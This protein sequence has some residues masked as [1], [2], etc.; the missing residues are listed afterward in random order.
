MTILN[1][2]S[3]KTAQNMQLDAGILV[4]NLVVGEE[5]NADN[6]LGATSGGA[7]FSATPTFRNLFADI[8]GVR[9]EI[10]EGVVID[11]WEVKLTATIKE[12]T[13]ENI[14]LA[15]GAVKHNVSATLSKYEVLEPQLKVDKAMFQNIS[16]VGNLNGSDE[17]VVIELLNVLNANGL[18]FTATDKGSGSVALELKAHVTLDN[19]N[20]VPFKVY[21]PKQA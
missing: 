10:A 18:S 15:L 11:S 2:F 7:T 8:D 4:K 19:P 12:I 14:S 6:Q 9:G 5:I 1:G 13:L 17:Y 21:I 3:P 20:E 16:W